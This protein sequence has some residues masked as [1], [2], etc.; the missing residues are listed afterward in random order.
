VILALSSVLVAT[1]CSIACALRVVR[2]ETLRREAP[3]DALIRAARRGAEPLGNYLSQCASRSEPERVCERIQGAPDT[4]HAIAELNE[5][6]GNVEHEL[7]RLVSGPRSW[8]R[9]SIFSGLLLGLIGMS[10]ALSSAQG[11]GPPVWLWCAG[12]GAVGGSLCWLLGRAAEDR[13]KATRGAWNSL[14]RALR[15]SLGSKP[16]T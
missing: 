16:P 7:R 12:A 9:V 14:I 8:M 6:S 4:R 3:T 5:A 1:I 13:A 15:G 2:L 11:L 10:Q